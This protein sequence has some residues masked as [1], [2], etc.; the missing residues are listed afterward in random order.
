MHISF[1]MDGNGRWAE[2]RKLPRTLG[3][4]EG[5]K[6]L[7]KIIPA[8]SE[9]GVLEATF[10]AFS[11]ENWK[12][13]KT[14]VSLLMKLFEESLKSQVKEIH[15]SNGV[16]RVVGNR[17]RLSPKIVQLIED[18]EHLT[19]DNTGIVINIAVDYG[20]QYEILSAVKK[21]ASSVASGE[22]NRDEIDADLFES[23]LMVK[24]PPDLLIRT[25]GEKRLSNYLLW[26]HAYSE[27]MFLDVLWPDFN[28]K[29]LIEC[30]EE[31]KKRNRRFG[32][33]S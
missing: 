23:K 20:G 17:D 9:Q 8:L 30:L 21:I 22:L 16:F 29:M 3:H 31:Y 14:E 33:L 11:T 24:N 25:G 32:G 1:I 13:P 19:K 4:R 2:S 10:Y 27:F 7:R 6:V 5:A 28:K 12:R 15:Q 18:S 26:Q